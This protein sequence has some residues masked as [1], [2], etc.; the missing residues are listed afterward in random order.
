MF[1]FNF[2]VSQKPAQWSQ[3]GGQKQYVT[4]YRTVST[5][6]RRCTH[7]QSLTTRNENPADKTTKHV[8]TTK[9]A[10]KNFTRQYRTTIQTAISG[11]KHNYPYQIGKIDVP[12]HQPQ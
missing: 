9:T 12:Q 3:Q 1:E 11:A 8:T 7:P 5:P 6:R 4:K 10:K 2:L